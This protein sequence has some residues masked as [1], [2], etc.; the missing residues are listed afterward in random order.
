ME[1]ELTHTDLKDNETGH[2][3][4]S[5]YLEL[6]RQNEMDLLTTFD[7]SNQIP[8]TNHFLKQAPY[9]TREAILTALF[10]NRHTELATLRE[11]IVAQYPET[12]TYQ[13]AADW[14]DWYHR[15]IDQVAQRTSRD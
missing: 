11:A 12:A 2:A 14:H 7:Q 6:F 8:E 10:T 4:L 1:N 5:F 13:T 3:F 9:P 15:V